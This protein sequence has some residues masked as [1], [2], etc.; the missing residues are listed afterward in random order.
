MNITI[1]LCVRS[2]SGYQHA[3]KLILCVDN[4]IGKTK[5]TG[6]VSDRWQHLLPRLQVHGAE[7]TS[8]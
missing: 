4:S 2:V 7:F 8:N 3:E 1:F 5:L 6:Y